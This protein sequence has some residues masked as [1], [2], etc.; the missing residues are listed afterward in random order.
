VT[1]G[2][3]GPGKCPDKSPGKS[4]AGL[5][6][7]GWV[8]LVAGILAVAFNMRAAITSLPPIFPELTTAAGLSTA[9]LAV[10]AAVPVLGFAA[11]SGVAPA[12]ARA[13]GEERVLWLA[14]VLLMLGLG[15]RAAAPG[16]LLFPGTIVASCAIAMMNVLLPSL[17][18]R[19]QPDRAGLLI[20]VY[21]GSL[22]AGAVL[23]AVIAV[24]LFD[25]AGG[26]GASVRLTLGIWAVPALLAAFVWLPQRKFRTVPADGG[27]RGVLSMARYPLTWQVTGCMGMQSLSYYATLSWFPTMFRDHGISATEAGNLLALMNVGNAVTALIVPVLAQ[28][29]RDQRLIAAG[30][31]GLIMTGIAGSAFAPNAIVVGFVA[32]LGLGQGAALGLAVFLFT[33][34]SADAHTAAAMSGFAQGA[35]YLVASAGP[36]LLGL[37]HSVT[38]GWTVPAFAL[39]GAGAIQL[40]CGVLAGRARTVALPAQ[41]AHRL[42]GSLAV[43]LIRPGRL[44]WR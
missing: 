9:T 29:A 12:L 19:R 1:S 8:L 41:P 3:P 30:S 7:A 24:P 44:A 15:L 40:T 2:R 34:R 11:F 26:A 10:L 6:A 36:L 38:G 17:I 27:R 5:P 42:A 32:L 37:L 28:R 14:L 39:L 23:G 21:L 16:V 43:R 33:A 13:F 35:G 25:A 18:K 4:P 20:G 22:T 31:A